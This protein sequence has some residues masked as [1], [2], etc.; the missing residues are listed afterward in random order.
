MSH[1]KIPGVD[2]S[3]CKTLHRS[4]K[5]R[6]YLTEDYKVIK[7]CKNLDECRREYLILKYCENNKYFP[8]VYEYHTGYLIREYVSGMCLIDYIKKN[9]LD[10][11]LALTLVDLIE[12]FKTLNFT[13]LDTGLSHIFISKSGAIKVIGLKNNYTRNEKYPKHMISGLKK[14]KV[15]KKFFKFLKTARPDIYKEWKE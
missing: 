1:P 14:L 2:L 5:E 6:I 10:E 7:I 13:R 9:S 4:K 11:T 3:K 15:S 12:N 8:K